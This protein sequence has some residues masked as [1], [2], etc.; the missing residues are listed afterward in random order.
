MRRLLKSLV[1]LV[2]VLGT[3]APHAHAVSTLAWTFAVNCADANGTN[4]DDV[5]PGLTLP[6]GT[7]VVAVAG[8]CSVNA[9]GSFT[10]PAG[11]PCSVPVAGAVPCVT[12]INVNNVPGALCQVGNGTVSVQA[13]APANVH[14]NPCGSHTIA[15]SGQ[16]V[17]LDAGLVTF[18]G[19][20]MNATFQDSNYADNVGAFL[21]TVVWTPA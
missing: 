19:G 14:L 7:Y 4:S 21:V 10:V 6:A 9:S 16:C 15:V 17:P 13:C 12:G 1:P 2:T 5:V 11:T 20:V 18:G 8:A 3:A